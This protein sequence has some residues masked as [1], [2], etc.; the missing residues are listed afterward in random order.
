MSRTIRESAL[1]WR[2]FPRT[3]VEMFSS[4]LEKACT[5]CWMPLVIATTTTTLV[6]ADY[7]III[8]SSHHQSLAMVTNLAHIVCM[9]TQVRS[10]LLDSTRPQTNISLFHKTV[11]SVHAVLY[12][13]W[14]PKA[15]AS[16]RFQH[17]RNNARQ[18]P[19]S[20]RSRSSNMQ[21][22]H[23]RTLSTLPDFAL[24]KNQCMTWP[25]CSRTVSTRDS[26]SFSSGKLSCHK[27]FIIHHDKEP[28]TSDSW[29]SASPSSSMATTRCVNPLL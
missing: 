6:V 5:T 11:V 9:C 7:H 4:S 27:F 29:L 2:C 22:M 10:Y 17:T 16:S 24:V 25:S 15:A 23:N 21:K 14:K 18:M 28:A 20:S 26:R 3:V 12:T 8:I 1:Q 13:R 19:N